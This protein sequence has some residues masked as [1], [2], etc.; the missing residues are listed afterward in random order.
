ML[1]EN[2]LR[3]LDC[4]TK[5]QLQKD[6]TYQFAYS[7]EP[8]KLIRELFPSK[9]LTFSF[10]NELTEQQ[11]NILYKTLLLGDGSECG[12]KTVY[13]SVDKENVDTFQYLCSL[14]GFASR[15][16]IVKRPNKISEIIRGKGIFKTLYQV[17]VK[18]QTKYTGFHCHKRLHKFITKQEYTGIVWCPETKNSTWLMRKN[19]KICFTGNSFGRIPQGVKSGIGIAEL[20][21]ADAT[22]QSDLVDNMEDFLV[23]VGKKLLR[24]IAQNYDVPKLIKALGKN[25]EPDHFV[26]VGEKSGKK[27]KNQ[28]EVRIGADVFKIAIIGADNEISVKIGSWL[29]YTKEA[30]QDKLKEYFEAGLID[31]AT[32]LEQSEFPN[33]KG[34]V[35]QTRRD[36]LLKKFRGTPSQGQQS[37][38]DEELAEQENVMMVNEGREVPVEPTDNHAVHLA[39]H[40]DSAD[41]SIVSKH[42][43]VHEGML[44]NPPPQPPQ[45]VLPQGLQTLPQPQGMPA[46]PVPPPPSQ[47]VPQQG[48][49]QPGSPEEQALLQSLQG[50]MGGQ[51]VG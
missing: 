36:E 19:G 3:K 6:G 37:I 18:D 10:V 4:Y 22:N 11:A 27:R 8:A 28:Q 38:G 35:E 7:K 30:Q 47:V 40:Q 26:A 25:G 15:L 50:V 31:Q 43:Y 44:S 29:A 46:A 32:F 45:P 9:K 34:I 42:M 24:E 49:P 41:N 13:Y 17:S 21:Q 48:V 23:R 20:K 1:I 5:P 12:T 33:V 16:S 14:L 39:I 51:N 2:C